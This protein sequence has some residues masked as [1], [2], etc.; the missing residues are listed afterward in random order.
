[1]EVKDQRLLPVAGPLTLRFVFIEIRHV[2]HYTNSKQ[3]LRDCVQFWLFADAG[4]LRRTEHP[5]LYTAT[6]PGTIKTSKKNREC[7]PLNK[8]LFYVG[9]TDK[10]FISS[11][12]VG[13]CARRFQD[14][15]SIDGINDLESDNRAERS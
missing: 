6:T 13:V 8:D 12:T 9:R 11:I 5:E 4:C 14:V 2:L 7:F 3:K 1:M 15:V 10:T